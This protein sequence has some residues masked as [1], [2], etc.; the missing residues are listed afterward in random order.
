MS[1]ML[2]ILAG[3]G[4]RSTAPF[5]EKV[6]DE[7]QAQYGATLDAD[8]PPMMIHSLPTPFTVDGPLD[9]DAMRRAIRGGLERLEHAGVAIAAIPCNVAH[10]WFDEIVRGSRIPVLDLIEATAEAV[11]PEAAAVSVLAVRATVNAGLY[12]DALEARGLAVR[13]PSAHQDRVDALVRG[14]KGSR[15]PEHLA[16]EWDALVDA[17]VDEGVDCAVLS[18]TDLSAIDA[19][20]REERLTVV[21]SGAAL[22]RRLVERWRNV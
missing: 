18:S 7:C 4:P 17:L 1:A 2:G 12:R 21:D 3:M 13:D 8:F 16:A 11:P 19:T 15:A 9:H 20:A 6:L 22:A 14:V 5:L 10:L